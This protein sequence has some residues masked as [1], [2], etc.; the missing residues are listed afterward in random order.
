MTALLRWKP[1]LL[2]SIFHQI[3]KERA[4][5][6]NNKNLVRES[7]AKVVPIVQATALP[8]QAPFNRAQSIN[9]RSR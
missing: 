9:P 8:Y 4:L 2:Q 7:F 6:S 1:L 5:K 3:R